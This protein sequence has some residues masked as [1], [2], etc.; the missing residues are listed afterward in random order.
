MAGRCV[1]AFGRVYKIIVASG[2]VL[3]T[4][5]AGNAWDIPGGLPDPFA[6]VTLN[7]VSLGRTAAAANTLMPVWNTE[8][9]ATVPGGSTVVLSATDEDTVVDP[10]DP[11]FG[12]Q[13]SPITAAQLRSAYL[14]CPSFA[15]QPAG[16]GSSMTFWFEAQ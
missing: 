11:M 9:S 1:A 13:L 7:S 10:D 2:S 8:F 14:T 15:S 5:A 3:E 6:T 12:C 16:L 4:D